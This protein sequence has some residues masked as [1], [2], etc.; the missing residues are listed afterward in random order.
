MSLAYIKKN[1]RKLII[2]MYVS[3][4]MYAYYEHEVLI[5]P[6]SYSFDTSILYATILTFKL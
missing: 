3:E 2:G 1:N 5:V 4:N 6:N